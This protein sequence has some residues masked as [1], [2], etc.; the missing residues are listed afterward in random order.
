MV[1]KRRTYSISGTTLAETL[2]AVALVATLFLSVFEMNGVCLH[3][4]G[5]SKSSV[6]ALQGVQDRMEQ[7]RNLPFLSLTS[8]ATI[9]A[10][11]AQ[12]ANG[13]EFLARAPTEV[14]TLSAYPT[15]NA[16][17]TQITL[18]PGASSA[19]INS[20]DANLAN[21]TLVK[22]NVTYT[23]NEAF[24]GRSRSEESETILSA[25]TKK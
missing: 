6:A 25:G 23:W 1:R 7:L 22:V 21:A 11:M 20:T 2:I 18:L 14:I 24:G 9:Q 3:Y 17:N 19:T 5:S 12:P 13:S 15:P 4:I 16:N 8:A 10:L